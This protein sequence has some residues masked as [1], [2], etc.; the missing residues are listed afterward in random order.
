MSTKSS[1]GRFNRRQFTIPLFAII[2][3]GCMSLPPL[4]GYE[5]PTGADS[6]VVRNMFVAKVGLADWETYT[7]LAAVDGLP[8]KAQKG[9]HEVALAPGPHALSISYRLKEVALPLR[10]EPRGLYVIRAELGEP[11][12]IGFPPIWLWIEDGKTGQPATRKI[13]VN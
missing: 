5:P 9:E 12:A 8:V 4:P 10:A 1:A 3:S 7:V 6:A 2:L 11:A 13:K